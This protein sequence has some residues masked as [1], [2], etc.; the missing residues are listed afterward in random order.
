[1]VNTVVKRK[2]FWV[3]NTVVKRK[4]FSVVNTVVK[5]GAVF[6]G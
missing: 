3:V 1:M 6:C 5:K 2:K 4:K